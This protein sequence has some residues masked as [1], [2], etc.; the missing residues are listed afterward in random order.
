MARTL[1]LVLC[2]LPFEKPFYEGHG[3]PAE[4]VG[5]PLADRLPL[6]ADRSAARQALAVSPEATLVA[7]L[8]G[9][10]RGEVE[11]LGMDFIGAA[12]WLGERRPG[13]EFLAPMANPGARAVFDRILADYP[14]RLPSI[15]VIDGRA[16]E[17]LTAADVVLVASGTATLETLLCKRPM[18]VAYRLGAATAWVA[19]RFRLMKAPFFSQPNLL[20]GRAVVPEIFQEQ[21]TPERL[22]AEVEAW[23]ESPERVAAVEGEFSRIH[24]LL[25]A[26]GSERAAEAIVQRLECG[27][28]A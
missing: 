25:Q 28:S 18:V 15:R 14:G 21:V 5:H 13:I 7:L 26:G 27:Q 6:V 19:R 23:L 16:S 10:R 9:S 2:L 24:R 3:L 20:A 12:A 8:P 4:F 11:R 17:A 22:G 1:D